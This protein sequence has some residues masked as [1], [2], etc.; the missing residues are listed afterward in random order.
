MAQANPFRTE[1]ELKNPEYNYFLVFKIELAERDKAKIETKIKTALSST[2]GSVQG[3]RL[4]ELKT[5]ILEVMCN[6]STYVVGSGY[7]PNSGGREKEAAAA[8]S[9]K[10]KDAVGI[11]EILCQTRKTLLKSDILDIWNTANK[12]VVYFTEDEFFKEISY[13]NGLGVKIID[14][15][16]TQI[17]FSDFQ[18]TDKRLELL[19]KKDLYDFLGLDKNASTA[20]IQ[21]TSDDLYRESGKT[22]DLKKKQAVSGLCSTV[23]KLLLDDAQKRKAYDQYIVLRPEVWDEFAQRKGFGI[24]ELS[25]EEYEDYTQKVIA[26]LKTSI[27]EA[28]KIIA[29]GCKFFQ[30]TIVGKSDQNSFES[31]PFP[32]CGKLYVKGAKSCPHCGRSLEVLCWNCKQLTRIT[33]EDKG[34]SV[35]GAT[36]HAQEIFNAHCQKFDRLLSSPS[37]DIGE[38]QSLFL[39]IKNVVPNFS[40]RSD[41]T[42]AKKVKDY[43]T[44]LSDRIKREE[45]IGAKYKE[46]VS[47]IQ[48]L[49]AQHCYQDASTIAKALPVKYSNYNTENSSKLISDIAA[50]MQNAQRQVDLAK[51]YIAQ[52]NKN[53]AISTAAKALDI[54]SDL[55]DARQIMQKF[56][57]HQVT[58]LHAII[59]KDKVRLEWEDKEKQDF[60]T[61]RIIKK[62]GIAPSDPDDGALVDSG[63]SVHFFEDANIVSAT[64]YYYAVLAERYGV[65]SKIAVIASPAVIFAD[66]VNM[67]QDVVDD[68]VKVVWETPQNVKSVEVW[69]NS[70]T[71]APLKPGEGTRVDC[72]KSGF[73]DTKCEGE[74]AYLI[75]CNYELSGK[76]IQS[77]GLRSVFKP[78]EKITPLEDVKIESIGGNRYIFTCASGYVG[79][80]KLYDSPTKLSIS[81]NSIQ[82]YLDF[83]KIC[84]GLH[85]LETS[86]NANGELTFSLPAG[87]IY[88]VY[89]IVSTEQLFIVSPPYLINSIVGISGCK[90]AEADGTVTVTGVVHPDA[91]SIIVKINEDRYL[92]NV[93]EEGEEFV[94]KAEEF[95]QKGKIEIKLK[96]NT[97]NYITLF[98]KFENDGVVSYAPPIKPDAPIDFREAVTVLYCLDYEVSREKPFKVTVSFEAGSEVAL[99]KL[100]LMQGSPKP[101]SKNA[102]KLCER[103]EGIVLKKSFF[104][105]KYTAK[106]VISANPTA[107]STKFA[108]FPNEEASRVQMKEVRKL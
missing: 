58:D 77:K 69:R 61:Y 42:V 21:K 1:E 26:Q 36:N 23:K 92:E 11:I 55:T 52:G 2:S 80:V 89:P 13:L 70:G 72:T 45:T 50:V 15:V 57:P 96:A 8:K 67:R 56:P 95:K 30:L 74:N 100:L 85:P 3:R 33:K 5:D 9:F 73:N 37:A 78:Y 64:P 19:G 4:I 38:L 104:S 35:C 14:N 32:D 93:S 47:K 49:I 108:L 27:E 76:V 6:D 31:C 41:S 88:Q 7:K 106:K 94:Y 24:K 79:K 83:N 48:Q 107:T 90:F 25:M 66:I 53:L 54:C 81:C 98:V 40:S 12:P 60:V 20:E 39:E 10:L 105:K 103:L 18:Q 65:F 43:D 75:V 46:E 63:L 71:V 16:D 34:C 97:V 29:I 87:K 51:Q 22:S 101:I 28:E 102:G 59:E 91:Q 44:V 99:P 84:K 82:R 86:V 68:G 62:I 17:P